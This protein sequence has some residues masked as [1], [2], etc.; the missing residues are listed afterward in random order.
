MTPFILLH[1]MCHPDPECHQLAFGEQI[2]YW[3]QSKLRLLEA[4]EVESRTH[5]SISRYYIVPNDF[6][7]WNI[8]NCCSFIWKCK[9]VHKPTQASC[10]QPCWIWLEIPCRIH[11][12]ADGS[13][14]RALQSKPISFQ[15]LFIKCCFIIISFWEGHFESIWNVGNSIVEM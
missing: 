3:K 5:P 12:W 1:Y 11:Q 14:R 9:W 2:V 7:D 6:T 4:F 15:S 8:I 10:W 13:T